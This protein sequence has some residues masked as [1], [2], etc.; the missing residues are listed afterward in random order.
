M[1]KSLTW[2]NNTGIYSFHFMKKMYSSKNGSISIA[3]DRLCASV[4]HLKQRRQ[5]GSR[6]LTCLFF[7]TAVLRQ[8]SREEGREPLLRLVSG[9]PED[10]TLNKYL[11]PFLQS[12]ASPTPLPPSFNCVTLLR[13]SFNIFIFIF[14]M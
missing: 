11:P 6:S 14:F 7:G 5:N 8:R 1:K 9:C 2:K 3:V 13:V 12:D 10:I 4:T